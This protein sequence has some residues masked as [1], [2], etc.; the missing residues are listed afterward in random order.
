MRLPRIGWL[1][2]LTVCV[3]LAAQAQDKISLRYTPAAGAAWQEK[4]SAEL[5]DAQ[6][7]GQ[8]LGMQGGG[9]AD[10]Q[11]A[12]TAVDGAAGNATLELG[13]KNV[14]VNVNG[15]ASQPEAP[16]PLTI[17]V[18]QLGQMTL[19]GEGGASPA[20]F[21]QTGG[22]PLQLVNILA[23]TLRF[24]ENP[25]GIGEQWQCQDTYVLPG[26]G[27]VP[28]TTHWKLTAVDGDVATITSAA[29]AAPPDFKA[30]NPMAPGTQLD[31][32]AARM[33]ITA[34]T[35]QYRLTD[36]RVLTAE[37]TVKV[38]A[39]IFMGDAEIPL[40]LSSTFALAQD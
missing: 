39:R 21:M 18:G 5:L 7:Q 17:V 26:M 28:V 31:V 4:L 32:R 19:R 36:S 33:S 9:Q 40:L 30:P 37:A 13:L 16:G 25:V 15:Q 8:P 35:Q 3:P 38:D 34:M 22:V 23:H 24:P 11:A 1:L 14:R 29:E 2:L 10:V 6:V 12:V 20:D 27:E